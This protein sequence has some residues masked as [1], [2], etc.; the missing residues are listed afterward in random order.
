MTGGVRDDV[1]LLR[2]VDMCKEK[3]KRARKMGSPLSRAGSWHQQRLQG[4]RSRGGETQCWHLILALHVFHFFTLSVSLFFF[5]L[6]GIQFV[7]FE[8]SLSSERGARGL[9]SIQI[10]FM[11][12]GF[13]GSRWRQVQCCF[14]EM[15][16]GT[17]KVPL[18]NTANASQLQDRPATDYSQAQLQQQQRFCDT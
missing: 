7:Y 3:G 17:G 14:C 5:G 13:E 9:M 12:Q 4:N 15:L 10:G 11:W 8:T 2:S 18:S 1:V 16:D 6:K